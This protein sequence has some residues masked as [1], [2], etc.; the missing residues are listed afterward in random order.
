MN[1][2]TIV[3]VKKKSLYLLSFIIIVSDN[4]FMIISFISHIPYL[5]L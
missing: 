2:L 1:I 4:E 3:Q 5:I